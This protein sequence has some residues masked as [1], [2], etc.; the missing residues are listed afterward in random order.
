MEEQT[1]KR[2][3]KNNIL[4]ATLNGILCNPSIKL[5]FTENSTEL[6]FYNTNKIALV[7]FVKDIA[8]EAMKQK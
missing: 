2:L 7:K 8:D 6:D 3:E 4:C 5:Y 1:L